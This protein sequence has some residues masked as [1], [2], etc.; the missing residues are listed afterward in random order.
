MEALDEEAGLGLP[1]GKRLMEASTRTQSDWEL[2][3]VS[4]R[5]DTGDSAPVHTSSCV[6][7]RPRSLMTPVP[8]SYLW[9]KMTTTSKLTCQMELN[10]FELLQKMVPCWSLLPLILFWCCM[11]IC[12]PSNWSYHKKSFIML[13]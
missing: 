3:L 5:A 11:C 6:Y 2:T 4:N 13:H 8:P 1:K 7:V 12:F 10:M 9:A